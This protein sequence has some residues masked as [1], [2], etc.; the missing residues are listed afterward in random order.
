MTTFY[1]EVRDIG[2]IDFDS[3]LG[4]YLKFAKPIFNKIWIQ[5][6]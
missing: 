3:P 1:N 6:L 2:E 5:V 4:K